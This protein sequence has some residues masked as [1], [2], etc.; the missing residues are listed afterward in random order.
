MLETLITSKTRIKLLLKFFLNSNSSSY[1]RSLANEFGEST[2]A[3]RLELN[4][5]E[6]AN[7]LETYSRG[8]KKMFKANIK[9]PMFSDIQR[10]IHKFV[11]IDKILE[12]VVGRLGEI[13]KVFVT[14]DFANGI[15]GPVIDL[16]IVA[17]DIDR[18]YLSTL[19][20]KTEPLIKRKIRFMVLNE[21]EFELFVQRTD[22]EQLLLIY[23]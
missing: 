7:I 17:D 2:N 22:D 19:I 9:H 23:S 21:N 5:F 8:N 20:E 12:K 15:D 16:L 10:L 13:N 18:P 11:G 4:R 3:I 6:E 1:L 14:G